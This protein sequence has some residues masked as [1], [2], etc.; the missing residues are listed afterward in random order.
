MS[1]HSATLLL[2]LVLG[3]GI[4]IGLAVLNHYT[5]QNIEAGEAKGSA[6]I[7]TMSQ[8]GT[9]SWSSDEYKL[10][11]VVNCKG[12]KTFV[13][14]LGKRFSS[15]FTNCSYEMAQDIRLVPQGDPWSEEGFV[16]FTR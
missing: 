2:V 10:V 14:R 15:E 5:S 7:S 6:I 12:V 16:T 4:I 1:K 11:A 9:F 3:L 13:E 8:T